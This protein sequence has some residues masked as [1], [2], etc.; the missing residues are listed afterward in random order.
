MI[1][2]LSRVKYIGPYQKGVWTGQQGTV[3]HVAVNNFAG[4]PAIVVVIW[5]TIQVATTRVS[6]VFPEMAVRV[7]HLKEI[8]DDSLGIPRCK[9][10]TKPGMYLCHRAETSAIPP[11]LVIITTDLVYGLCYCSETLRCSLKDVGE[12][13]IWWGPIHLCPDAPLVQPSEPP[14]SKE[15]P[16]ASGMFKT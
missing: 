6:G 2:R 4:E 12:G 3:K 7:E 5:D 14:Q 10:P 1:D 8:E 13:S 11:E 15:S 16:R 9:R